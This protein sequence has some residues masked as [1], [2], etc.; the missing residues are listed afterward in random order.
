MNIDHLTEDN[1]PKRLTIKGNELHYK[2]PPL[3]NNIYRYRCRNGTCKYFIKIN[4]T[5]LK[6]VINNEF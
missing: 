6:K 4:E 3:K 2:D 5:N 1:I